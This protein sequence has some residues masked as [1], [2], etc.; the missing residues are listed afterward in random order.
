MNN[1][2]LA[3]WLNNIKE[4]NLKESDSLYFALEQIGAC[5][6]SDDDD[7]ITCLIIDGSKSK[8]SKHRLTDESLSLIFHQLMRSLPEIEESTNTFITYLETID[9]RNNNIEF[10]KGKHNYFFDF[11]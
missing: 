6:K 1:C 9:F 8:N 7:T 11:F 10:E 5:K 4:S 2:S 3:T